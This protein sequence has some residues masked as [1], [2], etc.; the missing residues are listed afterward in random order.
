MNCILGM[1]FQ[2]NSCFIFVW[3]LCYVYCVY[4]GYVCLRCELKIWSGSNRVSDYSLFIKKY[5]IPGIVGHMS[6]LKSV[7]LQMFIVAFIGVRQQCPNF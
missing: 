4:C 5:E 7:E 6:N 2:L 3:L 1:H